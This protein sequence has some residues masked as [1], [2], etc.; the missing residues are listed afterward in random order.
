MYSQPGVNAL[1]FSKKA[2]KIPQMTFNAAL[3]KQG[4]EVVAPTCL[5]PPLKVNQ[6]V[7][8]EVAKSCG[9]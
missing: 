8:L 3:C 5:N 2:V 1:S 9:M 6:G 4:M 7:M